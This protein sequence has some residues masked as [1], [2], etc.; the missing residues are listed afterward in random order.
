MSTK[1]KKT[2]LVA[3]PG[4]QV[5]RVLDRAVLIPAGASLTDK[6]ETIRAGAF[7]FPV[8]KGGKALAM[9]VKGADKLQVRVMRP[10][11][12]VSLDWFDSVLA[13]FIKQRSEFLKAAFLDSRPVTR[14]D[15]ITPAQE[16][17]IQRREREARK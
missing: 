1:P 9:D 4:K 13:L 2:I 15:C 16:I 3:V 11:D 5:H 8:S 17:E 14:Q 12:R 10:E 6:R 7:H